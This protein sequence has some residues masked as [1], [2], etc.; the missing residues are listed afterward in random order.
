MEIVSVTGFRHFSNKFERFVLSNGSTLEDDNQ[1][2]LGKKNTYRP[3]ELKIPCFI[4][5]F[6]LSLRRRIIFCTFATGRRLREI[7]VHLFFMLNQI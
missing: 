6:S 4:L 1:F 3:C 5:P 7:Y 2:L